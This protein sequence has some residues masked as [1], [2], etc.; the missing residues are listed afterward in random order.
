MHRRD[1]GTRFSMYRLGV[2]SDCIGRDG[3]GENG[4]LGSMGLGVDILCRLMK[5]VM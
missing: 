4:F 5:H 2:C 1:G 3:E